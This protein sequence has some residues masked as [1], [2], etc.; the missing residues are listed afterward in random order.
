[1]TG[2]R[3]LGTFTYCLYD[4]RMAESGPDETLS[5]ARQALASTPDSPEILVLLGNLLMVRG[6]LAEAADCYR[7]ALVL[8]PDRAE[9]HSNLGSALRSQ[10]DLSAALACYRRALAMRPD[11]AEI[12]N[13]MGN[14]LQQM[15]DLDAA[16]GCYQMAISLRPDFAEARNNLGKV[17]DDQGQLEQAIECYREAVRH[18]PQS[19]RIHSNLLY[20]LHFHPGS[21][22]KSLYEEHRRWNELHANPLAGIWRPH[23]N[24]RSPERALRIGYLSPDFR[25]H[26]VGR[27]L[28]PLLA[29][30]D[31]A[32]YPIFCYASQVHDDAFTQRLRVHAEGWRNVFGLDDDQL[33]E[34]IRADGIDILVDLTMH[35]AGNRLLVFARKPAPV[36]VAYLAYCSTTGLDAMD[37]RL[38]SRDLDP[39][40]FNDAWYRERS[41]RLPETYWCYEPGLATPAVGDLPALRRGAITFGCLNNFCKVTETTLETWSRL[42]GIVDGSRLLLHCPV[43]SARERVR[44]YF[45]MGGITSERLVFVDFAPLAQYFERYRE[46]DIALDPFP[47]GGGTTTCDALWMGVPVVSLAG[48]TEVSRSGIE[49]LSKVGL[50]E[51]AVATTEQYV[52]TAADL[53]LNLARL[54]E[55]RMSLRQRMAKSP[56]MDGPGFARDVEAAY[57]EMWRRWCGKVDA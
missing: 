31:P 56:L 36:Q 11:A 38:T 4:G 35:M 10:G 45:V 57:R 50:A 27:F 21:T 18:Q 19:A 44:R 8:Q 30:H 37:Y 14:A 20:A 15:G 1:M 29:S 25:E 39:P 48:S 49:L 13:N 22:P 52:Q 32:R 16:I 43:G 2:A 7:R 6:E 23:A 51:L 55:L 47:Y 42:M 24:E 34:Q 12:H 9:V 17:Y 3:D 28:L 33:A 54:K 26:P 53:A 5:K 40:D 41:V 46:I